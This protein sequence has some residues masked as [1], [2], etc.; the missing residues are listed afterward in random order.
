MSEI[1][2]IDMMEISL[3]N[4]K[5]QIDKLTAKDREISAL[6]MDLEELERERT[7][8]IERLKDLITPQGW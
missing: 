5:R 4:T 8:I 6:K 7:I 2:H 3:S 1:K